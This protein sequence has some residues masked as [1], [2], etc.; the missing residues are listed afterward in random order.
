TGE[1]P[2]CSIGFGGTA[3][4][5]AV[6]LAL[7]LAGLMSVAPVL[8]QDTPDA[9]VAGT[10]QFEQTVLTDG[11]EGPWEITWG[12]D[13]WLWVTERT[14]GKVTRVNPADGEKK[15][16]IDIE[17]VSAPGGQDG[18]LGMALHPELLKGTGNDFVY[19]SYTYVDKSLGGIP[20]VDDPSS[21]YHDLWVKIVRL[22]YDEASGT[23]SE[24]Q[25]LIDAV[26]AKNDHNSGRLKFGP[27]SKLYYTI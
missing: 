3:M 16:A 21:P 12:P 11:L 26:P 13:G 23:L 27:D 8:A 18:L 10:K 7:A 17:E 6:T 5:A 20:W 19:V 14:G 24:P 22:T 9:A 4:K 15:V 2:F 25:V 1:A